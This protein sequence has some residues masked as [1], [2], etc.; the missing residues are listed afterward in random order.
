ME[1]CPH[2]Q[3]LFVSGKCADTCVLELPD[4]TTYAG[5]VPPNLGMNSSSGKYLEFRVCLACKQVVGFPDAMAVDF[6]V[7]EARQTMFR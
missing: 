5:Y 1:D 7:R 6:V 4:G 3:T 2:T